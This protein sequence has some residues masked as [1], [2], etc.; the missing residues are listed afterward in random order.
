MN[1]LINLKAKALNL[2]LCEE[3]KNKWNAAVDKSDL[4]KMALDAK[5]IDFM[6]DSISNGWGVSAEFLK[7]KFPEYINGI[8]IKNP[9]GYTSSMFVKQKTKIEVKSTL[10]L[11]VSC[12]CDVIVE[13][14]KMTNLYV[15]GQSSVNVLCNGYCQIYLYGD[16][17]VA[18]MSGS[19]K[20][21]TKRIK[22]SEPHIN[23]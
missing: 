20:W 16:S 3:Y 10:T 8:I 14:D 13:E 23:H 17:A 18:K 12:D 15:C 1:E 2:G 6:A 22:N 4:I 11:L 21:H 9:D 19:G 5:G 7:K